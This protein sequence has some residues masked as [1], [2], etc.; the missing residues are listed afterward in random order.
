MK[1]FYMLVLGVCLTFASSSVPA[2]SSEQIEK[3]AAAEGEALASVTEERMR[4]LS[5]P[6]PPARQLSVSYDRAFLAALPKAKGNDE[7]RCLAEALYFEARGETVRGQFAVAEVIMNRVD[8]SRYPDS[9]C[10]VITQGTGKRFQC[11][12]TYTCDGKKE[13][14][15]EPR[16]WTRVGKVARLVLDGA[17]KVLTEGAT[18][19][20]TKHVRPS[21]SRKFD[22]TAEIGVHLFYRQPTRLSQN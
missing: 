22:R 12:F 13:T 1:N 8:S 16:A 7:W 5:T 17:P 6:M 3:L 2:M 9:V 10:G 11:Q 4:L 19:Y 20:H 18:H 14:I 15:A 21:W